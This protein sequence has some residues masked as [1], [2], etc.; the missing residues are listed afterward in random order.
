[1]DQSVLRS[2]FPQKSS[3][4]YEYPWFLTVFKNFGNGRFLT[5]KNE[6]TILI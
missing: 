1:M 2:L 5:Q 3:V 6:I 4:F